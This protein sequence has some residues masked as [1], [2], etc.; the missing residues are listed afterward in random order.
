MKDFN[1]KVIVVTGAGSGMGREYALLFAKLGAKLALCDLNI[2]TLE[3]TKKL[4]LEKFSTQVFIQQL[5]IGDRAS[6]FDFANNVMNRLGPADVLI[7]NAGIEGCINSAWQM[8]PEQIETVMRI[9]FYGVVNGTQAFIEH[10]F[11]NGSGVIVNVS[12]IFGL[13]GTPLNADYCASKFAVR[14]YTEALMSELSESPIQVH[15]LHPGGID[16]NITQNPHSQVFSDNLLIT[17]A[18]EVAKYVVQCIGKNKAR[19]VIGNQSKK[20]YW[21]T[22]ILPLN[23]LT[24][25][26]WKELKSYI[27]IKDRTLFFSKL[28]NRNK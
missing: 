6:I 19:I 25:L 9:N 14:G 17:P 2:D 18:K 20:A 10:M 26:T 27:S 8:A 7:N 28:F 1:N 12:S 21:A 24:Y 4:V 13:L 3:Q 23:W 11:A 5:D 16:T 22:K 15:L